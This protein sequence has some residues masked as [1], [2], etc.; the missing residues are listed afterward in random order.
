MKGKACDCGVSNILGILGTG[1]IALCGIGETMPELVYG[2][3]GKD[4]IRSIWLSHPAILKLRQ[5]LE[6]VNDYPGVCGSCIHARSCRTGCV[7]NNYAQGGKLVA[8][9]TLCEEAHRLGVFP[10]SRLR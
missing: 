8:P 5:D 1:E 2:R 7:A 4:S 9:Q 10:K 6:N 3:L